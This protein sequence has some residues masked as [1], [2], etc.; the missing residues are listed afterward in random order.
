MDAKPTVKAEPAT[1]AVTAVVTQAQIALGQAA[2]RAL[3]Q[4]SN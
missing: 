3:L 2:L 4:V 1:T